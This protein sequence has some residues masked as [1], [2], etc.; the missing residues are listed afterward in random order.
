MLRSLA[1]LPAMLA[2]ALWPAA[3]GS[4]PPARPVVAHPLDPQAAVPAASAPAGLR[5]YRPALTPEAG[6]WREAND[7]VARIGGWKTY[8]REAQAPEPAASMSA[9]PARPASNPEH[10][11]GRP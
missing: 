8:L 3:A 4:Q 1:R 2:L 9:R 10:R 11:H 5:R 7:T 6:G